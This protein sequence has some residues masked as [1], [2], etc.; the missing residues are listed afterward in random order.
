MIESELTKRV[1]FHDEIA[2]RYDEYLT[3]SRSDILARK[4]FVDLV[5]RYVPSD[6]TLLDFGSGTGLDALEYARRGYH[7]LA[8]DNS[9]GMMAQLERRCRAEIAS[10]SITPKLMD[11]ESFLDSGMR[12]PAPQAV[13]ANFAVLNLIDEP[14]ILFNTFARHLAPPGWIII[15]IL[16]PVHWTKVRK[17]A[18]WRN[19][20]GKHGRPRV[21]LEQ[22]Y[23]AY[24]P[25]VSEVLRAANRFQLIGHAHA[26]KQV[27]FDPVSGNDGE[28]IW[29]KNINLSPVE[30]ALWHTTAHKLLGE[31]VFLVLRRDP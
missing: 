12:E 9:P 29:W 7:I 25:F 30:E 27:R 11:Y 8:Y 15:S 13:V 10:G 28:R 4:A 3:R 5:S 1:A 20:L 17:L 16:N 24:L 21:F 6:A 26:G 22:P 23:I 2:P 18:W 31:F 14:E 19:A